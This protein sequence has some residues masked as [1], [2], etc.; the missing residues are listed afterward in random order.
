MTMEYTINISQKLLI[1]A[2]IIKNKAMANYNEILEEFRQKAKTMSDRELL[3]E[4][5]VKLHF[6]A[7]MQ[8]ELEKSKIE[9]SIPDNQVLQCIN[10]PDT[11]FCQTVNPMSI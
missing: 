11:R 1:F 2:S 8:A 7:Y 5:Y 9:Y 4:I 10:F 3:E 6:V